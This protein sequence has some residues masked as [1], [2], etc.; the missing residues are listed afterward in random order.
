MN[1]QEVM[2][3]MFIMLFAGHETTANTLHY[4]LLLLAQ[5]PEIQQLVLDEIDTIYEEAAQQGRRELEYELDFNR[6][7]WTFAIMSETLRVYTPTG[8]TNKWT[9]TDQ[10]IAF[11]G[12][13]YV[14]PQGTRISI[15]GTAVHTNPKVW[16]DDANEWKPFRWI[17]PYGSG[18]S[19][20]VTPQPSRTPSPMGN[21]SIY[22]QEK[23]SS[24]PSTP[25]SSFLTPFAAQQQRLSVPSPTG[26]RRSSMASSQ[27]ILKPGILKPGK[28]TFLPFSEGSRACSGKKFATVEFV[29]VLFTLLREH[30][31]ELEDGWSAERVK[32]VLSGRKPGGITMQPPESIP[33]RF[34]RR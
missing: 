1:A 6:A 18:D 14:I 12:N 25:N 20:L 32:Q 30:R 3:N 23:D 19:P 11:E 29:A 34:V 15:N 2:G 33:L 26:S 28:G 16:G 10:P 9:A 22:P 5:H 13:T 17:M 24:I 7:H 4:S 31:L 27:G 21:R 8:M